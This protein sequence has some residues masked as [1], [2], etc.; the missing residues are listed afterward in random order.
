MTVAIDKEE[1]LKRLMNNKK[2]YGKLLNNF[3]QGS[4]V[5]DL[6]ASIGDGDFEKIK[7]AAHTL[8]GVAANL[9]LPE[10]RG[11]AADIEALARD[12]KPADELLP[13]LKSAA[14]AAGKAIGEFLSEE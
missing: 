9:A 13:V 14:G 1:G 7:A 8:K 2:L 3:L 5:D 4:A 11:V 10:L 6:A 12:E